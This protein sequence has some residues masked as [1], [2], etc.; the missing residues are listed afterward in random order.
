MVETAETNRADTLAPNN[1]CRTCRCII[2]SRSSGH[3]PY[4]RLREAVYWLVFGFLPAWFDP[5]RR[6]RWRIFLLSITCQRHVSANLRVKFFECLVNLRRR[7]SDES[8][9]GEMN[10]DVWG[11]AFNTG[12]PPAAASPRSRVPGPLCGRRFFI[13][14]HLSASS[15]IKMLSDVNSAAARSLSYFLLTDENNRKSNESE[16][17]LAHIWARFRFCQGQPSH[18]AEPTNRFLIFRM[19]RMCVSA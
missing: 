14:L 7:T 4:L 9:R 11:E 10:E 13:C 15:H 3:P 12:R 8:D 2:T 19:C 17:P 1:S 16:A 18:S 6:C 5:S